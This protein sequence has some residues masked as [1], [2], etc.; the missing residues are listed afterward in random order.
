[1]NISKFAKQMSLTSSSLRSFLDGSSRFPD[2]RRRQM[3]I[4]LEVEIL[5][6]TKLKEAIKKNT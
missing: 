6:M 4:L 2:I 1:M 5:R 3:G